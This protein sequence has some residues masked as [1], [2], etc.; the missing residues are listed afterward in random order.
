MVSTEPKFQI[1][2]NSARKL[3]ERSFTNP[4]EFRDAFNRHKIYIPNINSL[5]FRIFSDR[6]WR[7]M[8]LLVKDVLGAVRDLW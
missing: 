5:A 2:I 3:S 7:K 6:K 1:I 4:R 8:F